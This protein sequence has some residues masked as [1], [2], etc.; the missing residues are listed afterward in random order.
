MWKREKER[1]GREGVEKE[2]RSDPNKGGAQMVE[3]ESAT[4]KGGRNKLI[5][6]GHRALR[7]Q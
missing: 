4:N 5:Q 3:R 2:K 6:T 7:Q 1:G